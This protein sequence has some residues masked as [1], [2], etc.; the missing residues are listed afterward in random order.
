M[1]AVDTLVVLPQ[2]RELAPLVRELERCGHGVRGSSAGRLECV[3]V[4]E[5]RMLLA[6]GGHGKVQLGVQTQH[7]IEQ[8]PGLGIVVCA[9]SAGRLSDAL[10][11]GDVVV[12]TCTIEHDYKVRFVQRPLPRHEAH[13]PA[14]ERF[15]A[16]AEN[17]CAGF[18]VHF[19]PIA[20]GDEDIV[21][22]DRAR[23]LG[24]ATGAL[25]VAWEGAGAARAARFSRL[26]FVEVR[27]IT[28]GA[29]DNAPADFYATLERAMPNLAR[30]LSGWA[31]NAGG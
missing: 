18:R 16:V 9:G 5:L 14:I 1:S 27:A 8:L 31:K 21:D 26:P 24:E 6:V 22:R 4:P 25:C 17:G 20:S 10:D 2:A 19:G 13:E 23:H 29:D 30:V 12:G 3:L 7:L 11:L 15:R 28:D